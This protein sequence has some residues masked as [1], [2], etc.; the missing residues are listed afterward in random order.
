MKEDNKGDALS[1]L[2]IMEEKGWNKEE[3]REF[4]DYLDQRVIEVTEP[5][6]RPLVERMDQ[7][8][9]RVK[10]AGI[11]LAVLIVFAPEL[12]HRIAERFLGG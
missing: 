4:A 2:G 9:S 7:F 10:Q 3:I 1:V 11:G 6:I 8:E 5:I 12:V